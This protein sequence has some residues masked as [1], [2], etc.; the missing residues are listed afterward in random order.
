MTSADSER[1]L[2]SDLYFFYIFYQ[3][4]LKYLWHSLHPDMFAHIL[5]LIYLYLELFLYIF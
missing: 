4:L 2:F 3:D 1:E 5:V